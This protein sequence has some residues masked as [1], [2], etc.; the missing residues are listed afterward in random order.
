MTLTAIA[1][2]PNYEDLTI[3]AFNY[4]RDNVYP[5][6][7]SSRLSLTSL[8]NSQAHSS[9]V[10]AA[11]IQPG[12]TYITGVGHGDYDTFNGYFNHPVFSVADLDPAVVAQKVIHLLSCETATGLGPA[13]VASQCRAFFGYL[14]PFTYDP[15]Y[16]DLFFACDAQ[17]DIGL[18][19]GHTAGQVGADVKS[20]FQQTINANPGAASY[21]Q[22]NLDNFR[23]PLDG[24]RWGN[25]NATLFDNQLQ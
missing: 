23:S 3:A 14:I 18:A 12:V 6:L 2:D 11:A 9:P 10:A 19:A 24:P 15:R 16:S 17:I 7:N 1:V 13:M 25:V 22:M 5:S 21:L 8:V 4:R 20:F